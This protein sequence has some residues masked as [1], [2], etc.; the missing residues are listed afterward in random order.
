MNKVYTY[1]HEG[2][3]DQVFERNAEMVMYVDCP[4]LAGNAM[5]G[6]VVD[7][8]SPIVGAVVRNVIV[9]VYYHDL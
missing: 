9:D 1:S 5:A 3:T 4:S 7:E 6:R 2:M 8:G